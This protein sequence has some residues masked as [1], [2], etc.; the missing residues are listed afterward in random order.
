MTAIERTKTMQLGS[1]AH[2]RIVSLLV[3]IVGIGYL[4]VYLLLDWISFIE[5]YGPVDITTW[6]PGHW[7]K[8]CAGIALRSAHDSFLVPRAVTFGCH[9]QSSAGA[10]GPGIVVRSRDRWR[11]FGCAVFF[12]ASQLAVSSCLVIHEGFGSVDARRPVQY[13]IRGIGLRFS[14][15]IAGLLPPPMT[16]CGVRLPKIQMRCRDWFINSL[17]WMHN[18][19]ARRGTRAGAAAQKG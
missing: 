13:G 14:D 17:N 2:L 18:Q 15:H 11:L 5:P 12:A 6:N 10:M 1:I 16:N 8:P 3:V 4:A 9:P 7:L 19:F